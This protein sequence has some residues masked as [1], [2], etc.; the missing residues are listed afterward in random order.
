MVLHRHGVDTY[1]PAHRVDHVAHIEALGSTGCDRIVAI[2]SV[3]GLHPGLGVG[4]MVMPDDFIAL[5]SSISVFHDDRSHIVPG[6]DPVW[7]STVLH[8][9]RTVVPDGETLRDAGVYWQSVGP[10]FE[11][12]AEIRF[13]ARFADVVGMT[14]ASECIAAQE[15]GVRMRSSAWSTTWR[16]ASPR[17]R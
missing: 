13:I 6:F 2:S 12:R 4:T 16:T 11:T 10:R 17:H 5:D 9:A 14:A 7:R 15:L 1:T 8:A 3:G